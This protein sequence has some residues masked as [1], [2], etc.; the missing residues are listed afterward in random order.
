MRYIETLHEGEN[1]RSIYLCKQKNSALT[2]SGKEYD[3]VILQDKTGQLDAKIWEPNS[4]GIEDFGALDYVEV[5]GKV[6]TFNG[7]IQLSIDRAR[8]CSEGEYNESDYLPVS[9]RDIEEMYA[10]LMGY[11]N[12]IKN[13]QINALVKAFF[14][15]D[16]DFITAFKKSSAAKS[17]HHGFIGGLLEHTLG[18]TK[19]CAFFADTYPMLKKDTLLASAMFHDMGKIKEFSLFPQND[20]T[21]D[22]QLPGHMVMGIEMLDEKL[23][24]F[25]DF[26]PAV[27]SEIKHCILSHHGEYEFGA[28]KKPATAEGLALHF[29][30]NMDAKMET[31]REM[32]ESADMT[33]E[34]MGYSKLLETNIKRSTEV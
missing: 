20:Y 18:V 24:G 5:T 29:A 4:F 11:V 32:F 14:V 23:R 16:A 27:A 25:S 17:V 19:L 12:M 7:S 1:I 13:P 33:R 22:G 2:K 9:R 10:E 15:E 30:D 21:D 8:K 6:T 26:S 3:N 28:P 31:L 34:W